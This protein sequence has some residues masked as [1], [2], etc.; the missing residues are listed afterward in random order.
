MKGFLVGSK[1][2]LGLGQASGGKFSYELFGCVG[3]LLCCAKCVVMARVGLLSVNL[4]GNHGGSVTRRLRRDSPFREIFFAYVFQAGLDP[5]LTRFYHLNGEVG[6]GST[7]GDHLFPD[8]GRI[9]V[10]SFGWLFSISDLEYFDQWVPPHH[11]RGGYFSPNLLDAERRRLIG[12]GYISQL[13]VR[14]GRIE[15][16]MFQLF[17][18]RPFDFRGQWGHEEVILTQ[19]EVVRRSGTDVQVRFF[20]HLDTHQCRLAGRWRYYGL[21]RMLVLT[22]GGVLRTGGVPAHKLGGFRIVYQMMGLIGHELDRSRRVV[23][24]DH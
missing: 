8:G 9:H 16:F 4:V 15:G 19:M 3:T 12:L 11:L 18:T 23:H 22:S 13:R 20:W 6:W 17:G 10:V 21:Y 7:P 24:L 5:A 2:N 1:V 14:V